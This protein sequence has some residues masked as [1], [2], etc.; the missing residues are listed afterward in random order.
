MLPQTFNV[1]SLYLNGTKDFQFQDEFEEQD[2]ALAEFN[3]LKR[4]GKI[5]WPTKN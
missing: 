4:E 3:R 5:N 2:Q 1:C